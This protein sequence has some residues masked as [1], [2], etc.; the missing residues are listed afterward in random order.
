MILYPVTRL[1]LSGIQSFC[2]TQKDTRSLIFK[3]FPVVSCDWQLIKWMIQCFYTGG[4]SAGLVGVSDWGGS[5]R[6]PRVGNREPSV[7][8]WE[9]YQASFPPA[10]VG[11]TDTP[12]YPLMG[13][14]A[15]GPLLS[16]VLSH[17]LGPRQASLA[18]GRAVVMLCC[19]V[20][21]RGHSQQAVSSQG[22][23]RRG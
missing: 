2:P 4:C 12:I 6:T 16:P 3:W 11:Q 21:G 14:E 10:L 9:A 7:L 13:L 18:I 23:G 15:V 1:Q 20:M 19:S 5:L 22:L 8:Q 17:E